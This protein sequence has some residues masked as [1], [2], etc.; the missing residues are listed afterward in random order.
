ML[1]TV[2]D[3]ES[4]FPRELEDFERSRL[5]VLL[6]D[7]EDLIRVAFARVGRDLDAELET[8]VLWLPSAVRRVIREMVSSAVGVGLNVGVRSVTSTSGPQSDS[9]TFAE[10]G[11]AAWGGVML[12]SA[13]R[14][15]LGLPVGAVPTGEFPRPSRWPEAPH[16]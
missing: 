12:S 4:R 15:E 16:G 9:I 5:A 3:V 2:R 1:V 11:S 7:A 10:V 6:H 8:G 13:H 14:L